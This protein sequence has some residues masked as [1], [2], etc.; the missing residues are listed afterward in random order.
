[1]SY[2]LP[3][4]AIWLDGEIKPR[5]FQKPSE[6]AA[7][8]EKVPYGFRVNRIS[9][10]CN[11]AEEKVK[12]F[13]IQLTTPMLTPEFRERLVQLIKDN[14]GNVP[15]SMKLYDPVHKWNI[16]FASRKFSVAVSSEFVSALSAMGLAYDIEKKR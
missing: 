1:M 14:K 4:T 15:L 12:N 10:L 5:F 7:K 6:G 13:T 2:L 16:E 9:L 8:A 11:V 3:H